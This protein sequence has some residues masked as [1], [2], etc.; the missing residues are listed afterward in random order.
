MAESCC[1][2][3]VNRVGDTFNAQKLIPKK[4]RYDFLSL[5]TNLGERGAKGLIKRQ[6]GKGGNCNESKVL[7][8]KKKGQEKSGNGRGRISQL[9]HPVET[10][11]LHNNREDALG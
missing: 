2:A 6:R 8:M 3:A 4:K 5:I 9:E 11:V 1:R 7:C 10:S